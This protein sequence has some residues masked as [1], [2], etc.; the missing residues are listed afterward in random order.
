MTAICVVFAV[1]RIL[2]LLLNL[3]P[4]LIK[5]Y[6]LL[7][8]LLLLLLHLKSFH[9]SDIRLILHLSR[10]QCIS[11]SYTKK[12]T[13]L[14]KQTNFLKRKRNT[15]THTHAR[16]HA[17]THTH[18][19]THAHTHTHT[20]THTQARTHTNIHTHTH[21]HT[22]THA[23]EHTHTHTHTHTRQYRSHGSNTLRRENKTTFKDPTVAM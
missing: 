22:G 3:Y 21:T 9:I 8:L 14:K 4:C 18:T 13:D 15:H 20:R 23:H 7:L 12:T 19:H 16:T 10:Q 1:I 2:L 17:R 11:A 5:Y 6:L